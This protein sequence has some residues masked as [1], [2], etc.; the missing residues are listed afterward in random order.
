[1]TK[2]FDR[3]INHPGLNYAVTNHIPRRLASRLAARFAR[4]EQPLVRDLS[5]AVWQRCAGDLALHEARETQ[6]RSLHEC[7]IRELKPGMRPLDPDPHVLV[8]PA[9]GIVVAHGPIAETTL[10]QAKGHRYTLEDLLID[11]ALV[12]RLRHG[13]YVTL[14]LTASMY[15]RFH[16]PADGTIAAVRF[17]PGD[18]WNVNPP[19]LA[20]VPRVYCRNTRAIVPIEL[21]E[22]A[23]IVL[24]PVG[25]I[26][27]GSIQLA[28][29]PLALDQ[30]YR[31][32]HAI[33]CGR[34]IARGEEL[35]YFRHGS[36]IVAL[37]PPGLTIDAAVALDRRMRMGDALF[38]RR[39]ATTRA[40]DGMRGA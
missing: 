28:F 19:T 14:R 29:L 2:L 8:S 38:R 18:T 21:D 37:A 13:S 12:A 33:A 1:M 5:I 17:V 22:G 6:F 30:G 27:V 26:L 31:G 24:V 25:A 39:A 34:R 40:A 15:H 9:D 20:R 4:I 36:T 3:L 16:A 10:V 23:A 35:G 7:F 32:P 11:P